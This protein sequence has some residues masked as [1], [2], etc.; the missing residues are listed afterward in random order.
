MSVRT[1]ASDGL[2]IAV[3]SVGSGPPI[4]FAHGLS[5]TR[6]GTLA[7]LAPLAG[8]YRVVAY[9]QRGHHG[10]T[11]VTDPAGYD[12]RRMAEDMTA[13]LDALGI[14]RAIVGGESM[15]AATALLFALAHPDR[16]ERLL[17]TAP[18]FGDEPNPE[19]QRL[20]DMGGALAALGMDAFLARAAVRQRDDL[21][22]S[23]AAIEHVRAAFAS[24][25]PASLAVALRTVAEWVPFP[26]LGVLSSVGRPAHV[27]AWRDDPLHPYILAERVSSA[28]GGE[29]AT[30]APL[31]AVFVEPELV[32]RTYL[33]ALER[34]DEPRPARR[35]G[36]AGQ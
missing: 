2:A 34:A 6:R 32:G 31:P 9:D 13:V 5:G 33:R 18:A 11:P 36:L 30:I 14:A 28:L 4:V 16:V 19:R 24:H 12:P 1:V 8:R 15:G 27:I 3:E 17:I 25:D 7:Q 20:R 35:G 23:P 21:G 29:L 26:D 22:W 10:S